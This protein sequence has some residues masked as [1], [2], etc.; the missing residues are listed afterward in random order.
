[1]VT[2]IYFSWQ[3]CSGSAA[4]N[5]KKGDELA[6][7]QGVGSHALKQQRA[8]VHGNDFV[9]VVHTVSAM[10][11]THGVDW[12]G[13]NLDVPEVHVVIHVAPTWA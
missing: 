4:Q 7:R 1:M 3:E 5:E 11:M 10:D 8:F 12:V 13:I 9:V 6:R 2:F